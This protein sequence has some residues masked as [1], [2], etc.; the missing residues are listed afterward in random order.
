MHVKFGQ[1]NSNR[2]GIMPENLRRLLFDTP[3][4][5]LSYG[6]A[7]GKMWLHHKLLGLL[8]GRS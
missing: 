1:K 4:M 8:D 5:S 7:F 3:C 6:S 2:L